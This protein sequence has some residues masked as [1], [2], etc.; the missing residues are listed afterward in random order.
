MLLGHN[1]LNRVPTDVVALVVDGFPGAFT[2]T[3]SPK[4]IKAH[5][6]CTAS[7]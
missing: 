4:P 6:G 2:R 7:R 3:A 5:K 1:R